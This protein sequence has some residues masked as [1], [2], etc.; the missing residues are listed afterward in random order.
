M[1]ALVGLAAALAGG[2]AGNAVG[3]S[4]KVGGDKKVNKI[5]GPAGALLA[6]L[7][8]KKVTGSDMSTE[9]IAATGILIGTQGIGLYSGVKNIIQ[10]VKSLLGKD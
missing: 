3:K 10:G 8:F 9:Q 4:K 2:A 1:D 5:L 7:L 6:A